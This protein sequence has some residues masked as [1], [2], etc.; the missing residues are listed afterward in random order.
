MKDEIVVQRA[1]VEGLVEYAQ[2]AREHMDKHPE[3]VRYNWNFS[4]LIGY[5]LSAESLLQ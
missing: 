4:C 1:W 3:D 2:K 5:A